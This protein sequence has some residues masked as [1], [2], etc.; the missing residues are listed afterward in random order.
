MPII[1]SRIFGEA[2]KYPPKNAFLPDMIQ[3]IKI[4]DY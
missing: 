3:F 4:S 1:I 2:A